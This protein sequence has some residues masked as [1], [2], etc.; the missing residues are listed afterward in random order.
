MVSKRYDLGYLKAGMGEIEDY[1]LSN[2]LYWT[3]GSS[4]PP[5]EPIFPQLTLGTLLLVSKRL[6]PQLDE[7]EK[8]EFADELSKLKKIE[9]QW[10]S[11]WSQK[12]SREFQARL[13]LWRN[14]LDDYR[15]HPME[16]YDRYAYEVSRRVVIDLLRPYL[17][18][19]STYYDQILVGLDEIL[20][21][22]FVRSS[23]LWEKG[24]EQSFP[25]TDYWYLYGR[26]SENK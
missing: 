22:N 24:I 9:H 1:L 13:N 8:N 21:G 15:D 19:T 11:A 2:Q 5:G 3:L 16:N 18:K 17:E 14:Y 12:A 20:R 7:R 6:K 23:F 10:K 26:L 25:S 4:S